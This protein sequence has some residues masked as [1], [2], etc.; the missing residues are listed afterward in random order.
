MMLT[1]SRVRDKR[2][3]AHPEYI[4]GYSISIITESKI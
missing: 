3:K 2:K 4:H 1:E